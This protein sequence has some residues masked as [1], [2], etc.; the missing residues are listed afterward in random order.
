M[1]HSCDSQE[2]SFSSSCD[3]TQEPSFNFPSAPSTTHSFLRIA[4]L[5]CRGLLAH[6]DDVLLFIHNHSIDIMTLSETWL[7]DTVSDL[8]VCPPHYDLNIVRRDRNRRGGGVAIIFSNRVRY[9]TCSDLSERSVESLWV[10]LFP[11]S[12]RA[13]LM[14]CAY[15]SP[16]DCHFFDNLMVECEKG[17]LTYC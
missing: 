14:C 8:E 13:I 4:H 9:R 2:L 6:H 12:K 16:S 17:L 5:N 10:E 3:S 7:D 15:R 11:N 1:K